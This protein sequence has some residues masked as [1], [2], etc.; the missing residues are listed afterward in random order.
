[1]WSNRVKSTSDKN[2]VGYVVPPGEWGVYYCLKCFS[3]L[4]KANIDKKEITKVDAKFVYPYGCSC[5]ECDKE[6]LPKKV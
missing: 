5:S 2:L 6:I 3:K 4:F 1:M